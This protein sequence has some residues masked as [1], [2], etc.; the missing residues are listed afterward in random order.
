[1]IVHILS[2]IFRAPLKSNI[3]LISCGP[4]EVLLWI[5]QEKSIFL[6]WECISLSIKIWQINQLDKVNYLGQLISKK[7]TKLRDNNH[8]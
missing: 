6:I 7:R 4:D 8:G 5:L 2:I 3:I 1:M